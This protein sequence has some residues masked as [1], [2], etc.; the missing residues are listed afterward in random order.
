[1]DIINFKETNCRN[2][3][4]CL[5]NCPVKAISFLEG[6]AQVV[7][8]KCILCGKC[9]AVC[10]QNAKFVHSDLDTVKK[11]LSSECR[12][13][14]S[15]APSYISNFDNV[16]REMLFTAIKS[17][18]FYDVESTAVGAKI[19][20]E[21]YSELLSGGKYKNFITSACPAVVRL[22]E[23]SYPEA[24]KYI[25]PIE[26]PMVVHG[27]MIKEKHGIDVKVVFI[28]PCIAKKRE[29]NESDSIDI[30]LTFAELLSWFKECGID[31]ATIKP[32][33]RFTEVFKDKSLFYPISRGIIKSFYEYADGY[34]YVYVDGIAHCAEVLKNIDN[35]D[36]MMIEMSACENSCVGGPC[37]I[38][39]KG[40]F[41]KAN[42]QVRKYAK[43]NSAPVTNIQTA[44]D[45]N[46]QLKAH[47]KKLAMPSEIQIKEILAKIGKTCDEDML[48]CGACGYESCRDKAVAVY[49]GMAN[50]KMCLPYMQERAESINLEMFQNSPNAVIMADN[51]LQLLEINEVARQMYG[52]KER[53]VKGR[54]IVDF[55]SPV[56]FLLAMNGDEIIN[57]KIHI[58]NTD[59]WG[60]MS[61][62]N[63]P[64]HDMIMC[65]VI[66]I[67]KQEKNNEKMRELRRETVVTTQKVIEKQMSIVQEIASLLGETTAD[68]KVALT[69][70]KNA[71]A[72]DEEI[73]E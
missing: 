60:M 34:D 72:K 13:I 32:D 23:Y 43:S 4:K 40:G 2:C 65:N 21:K 14:A 62:Y 51:N 42:E 38:E 41:L 73:E 36:G 64:K 18:G 59:K 45:T 49:N 27:R 44:V 46:R 16:S 26:S 69:K 53:D 55:M 66:D 3:Y 25:A 5:R 50:L 57:K 8:A 39:N 37:I 48:N 24:L 68:T 12:V 15:V 58:D 1:M 31:I 70:L 29:A 56:E 7:D 30:A 22:A 10:P 9:V 71:V 33:E 17:L 35:L 20:T 63:V 54:M 19:V 61:I 6:N 52:I 67:T 11:L 28:G 47:D